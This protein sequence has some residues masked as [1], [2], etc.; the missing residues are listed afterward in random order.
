[1]AENKALYVLDASVILKWFLEETENREQAVRLKDE[2]IDGDI[3]ISI[4]FYAY[5]EILNTLGRL[6]SKPKAISALSFLYNLRFV[7]YEIS[8]AHAH[9]AIDIMNHYQAVSFYDAGYHALALDQNI[10]LITADKKYY[11]KVKKRG[12][13]VFLGDYK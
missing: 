8:Y 11:Q 3:K 2:Y 7:E 13:I 4:P 5:S 1:M 12:N 10:T 9:F 6:V